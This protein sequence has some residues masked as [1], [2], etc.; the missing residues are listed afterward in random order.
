MFVL[1]KGKPK[2]FNPLHDRT[3]Y[4]KSEI[5]KTR[6][7]TERKP[8][9]SLVQAESIA[10]KLKIKSNIWLFSTGSNHTTRYKPAYEH[11][12]MFPE[13]LAIDQIRSW[14]NESDLILDPFAGA[15]TSKPACILVFNPFYCNVRFILE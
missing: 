7:K 1:S 12:A 13:Q 15:G 10:K 14:T 4:K 11:P 8:D 6:K 3:K 2:T 5:G 9:G